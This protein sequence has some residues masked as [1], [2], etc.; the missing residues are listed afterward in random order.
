MEANSVP[1]SPDPEDFTCGHI[2]PGA[3]GR[4][5]QDQQLPEAPGRTPLQAR[6]VRQSPRAAE[7]KA[8][9]VFRSVDG[10]IV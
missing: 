1:N 8:H 3:W 2:T 6:E 9:S 5:Q 4:C 7:E 10:G